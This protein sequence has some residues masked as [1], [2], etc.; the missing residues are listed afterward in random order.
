MGIVR[1]TLWLCRKVLRRTPGGE[2]LPSR[3]CR[4]ERTQSNADKLPLEERAALFTACDEHLGEI[5]RILEP[6]WLIGI[7]DFA[8]KRARDVIASTAG[9]ALN[10]PR[11]G[12]I[13]HPSPACPAS[14]N[15]WARIATEQLRNLGVWK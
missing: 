10:Q 7:G 2:L 8:V 9:S 13:L 6:H 1:E 11:V 5:I 15:D 12:Q 14:N 3:V 4:I